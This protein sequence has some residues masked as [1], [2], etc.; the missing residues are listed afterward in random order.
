MWDSNHS[1]P[2][3]GPAGPA[4]R[5][6]TGETMVLLQPGTP[7][8]IRETQ[9]S[10]P[11]HPDTRTPA[12]KRRC[13]TSPDPA[14]CSLARQVAHT[15]GRTGHLITDLAVRKQELAPEHRSQTVLLETSSTK[16]QVPSLHLR[17]YNAISG[18]EREAVL[19][20]GGDVA[21]SRGLRIRGVV[22]VAVSSAP[23]C[24]W[25]RLSCN[26]EDGEESSTPHKVVG[27]SQ[28]AWVF[29]VR[30]SRA[31]EANV[32]T[33]EY[34]SAA[35]N[36]IASAFPSRQQR[37]LAEPRIE[38]G[39]ELRQVSQRG[40]QQ[41]DGEGTRAIICVGCPGDRKLYD[42]RGV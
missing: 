40:T 30:F 6:P 3:R 28:T 18:W 22:V 19:S 36:A 21:A 31:L 24:S 2:H 13:E 29:A 25:I 37:I 42:H 39:S 16:C 20:R 35:D 26:D 33:A 11:H 34:G 27:V 32:D 14:A 1:S 9:H 12:I 38:P 10:I 17:A 41:D 15:H 8:Q 23:R 7:S 5:R 4:I